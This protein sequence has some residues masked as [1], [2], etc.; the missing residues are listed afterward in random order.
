MGFER[1]IQDFLE[2]SRKKIERYNSKNPQTPITLSY[3]NLS[4][5]DTFKFAGLYNGLS[6]GTVYGDIAPAAPKYF[7]EKMPGEFEKGKRNGLWL[8][9][10]KAL[11][12]EIKE[13]ENFIKQL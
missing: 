11:E 1:T 6:G 12:R 5:E 10:L 13:S 9:I 7:F 2:F 3:A 4:Y 8:Q